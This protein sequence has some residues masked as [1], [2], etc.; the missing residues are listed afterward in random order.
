MW[1]SIALVVLG[2][3]GQAWARE[4]HVAVTGNDANSGTADSP[5]KTIQRAAD[6]AQPGDAVVIHGGIYRERVNPPRGGDSDER[7][8]VYQAAP[9]ERVEIRGSEPVTGWRRVTGDVWCVTLPPSFFGSFNPFAEPLR[10]DWFNARGRVHTRGAVYLDGEW[11]EPADSL[12]QLWPTNPAPTHTSSPSSPKIG[13]WYAKVAESG[14]TVWAEFPG[15]DPNQRLV[16]VNVRPVV[17]YPDRPG[18]NFITVRGLILRHAATQW[19]PPTAEQIGVI[20]THWSKGW[21]IESNVVSHS[22]CVGI[23]LGKY[24]DEFDNT[25]ADTA[26]GYVKTI[27]RALAH[28]IPWTR[29]HIGH[30]IVRGNHISHCE[31]AG[32]VGSLGGA[33]SRIEG[34]VIHDIHVRRRFGGAEQAGI[35]LHGAIDCVL[36]RNHIFRCNRGIWLDWM[37][38]GARVTANLLHDNDEKED[39]FLEV[40]HGPFLVDHNLLLSRRNL[41]DWSQG[42]AFAHNLFTGHLEARPELKRATPWH[43][44]HSTKIGG[45][46]VI[47]GGDHRFFN[48]LFLGGTGLAV[49]DTAA[50]PVRM[51]GN[52]FAGGARPSV[53]ETSPVVQAAPA[54]WQLTET[55]GTWWIQVVFDP[56]WRTAARRPLVTTDL[57]G[58][59]AVPQARFENPDGTPLELVADYLGI[60]RNR[61]NPAP[62][63]FESW[64]S[65]PTTFRVW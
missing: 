34:N 6:M 30:H 64:P 45:L 13:R 41:R 20:G 28:S 43:E 55:N 32:I 24:G 27:E 17:F 2:C 21:I 7:R 60:P 50:R 16:E 12:E 38:Q 23:S 31:Q 33:F 37:A 59:A 39:L 53:H 1:R 56:A 22:I 36:A 46:S 62:G 19:A 18:R 26:E 47:E 58:M 61:D 3:A 5:L 15:V 25:S 10:G 42:G 44:P 8:I 11:L 48:N 63:P 49:Y 51:A 54:E 14:T 29:E 65:S 57:L 9:G 40:N 52:V 4:Y 35:K